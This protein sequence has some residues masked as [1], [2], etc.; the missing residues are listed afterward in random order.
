MKHG[1]LHSLTANVSSEIDAQKA[2]KAEYLSEALARREAFNHLTEALESIVQYARVDPER[3]VSE[4]PSKEKEI[5]AKVAGVSRANSPQLGLTLG[6]TTKAKN[7]PTGSVD[8][9]NAAE[10]RLD[11]KAAVFTPTISVQPPPIQRSNTA[12]SSHA[13]STLP[14]NPGLPTRP[15]GSYKDLNVPK[16][17]ASSARNGSMTMAS[18]APN[19]RSGTPLGRDRERSAAPPSGK[20]NVRAIDRNGRVGGGVA[21]GGPNRA[22]LDVTSLSSAA[23]AVPQTRKAG[24]GGR[25]EEGEMSDKEDGE[26]SSIGAGQRQGLKRTRGQTGKE[27]DVEAKRR[28]TDAN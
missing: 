24:Q 6:V 18:S 21:A 14:V 16:P 19:S 10:K 2:K 5:V 8:G 23:S 27:A 13:R 1:L 9:D 26:L 12:T 7:T 3:N 15:S 28:R 22:T 25:R 20:G 4:L 11:P 17:I